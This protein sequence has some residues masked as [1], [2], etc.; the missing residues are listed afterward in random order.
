MKLA[1]GC[2]WYSGVKNEAYERMIKSWSM[3]EQDK[4][5]FYLYC[6]EAPE[7]TNKEYLET[8]LK[9]N[10]IKNYTIIQGHRNN[11]VYYAKRKLAFSIKE[12]W[13]CIIDCGDTFTEDF[14][15]WTKTK[16]LDDQYN[17]YCLGCNIIGD[18]SMVYFADQDNVKKRIEAFAKGEHLCLWGKVIQTAT[19]QA[20]YSLLPKYQYKFMF[21]E[22]NIVMG[23][24]YGN[25]N[26]KFIPVKSINYY[27][28]GI[29]NRETIKTIKRF[30]MLLSSIYLVHDEGIEKTAD[31]VL[32]RFHFI[33]DTIK[34]ECYRL[35][36]QF[37]IALLKI[38]N[39][40][41]LMKSQG[42]ATIDIDKY[43]FENNGINLNKLLGEEMRCIWLPEDK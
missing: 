41:K 7:D 33:D 12:K 29:S 22:E 43:L 32:S 38:D 40:T 4:T 30:K 27:D 28:D 26:K 18:K 16:K 19:L 37:K 23:L 13:C 2:S 24:I 20:S 6:D 36:Q 10:Q 39:I 3:F 42:Y 8:V 21:G 25:L 14:I 31:I 15:K 34:E 5:F 35:M 17:L 11:C 9:E 1:I